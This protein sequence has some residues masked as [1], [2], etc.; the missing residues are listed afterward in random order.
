MHLNAANLVK[1]KA[2]TGWSWIKYGE[3][4][5]IC[6]NWLR[7]TFGYVRGSLYKMKKNK[8]WLDPN[9]F[10]SVRSSGLPYI[11]RIKAYLSYCCGSTGRFTFNYHIRRIVI[12]FYLLLGGWLWRY[13]WM[14]VMNEIM[15]LPR[16]YERKYS[17]IYDCLIIDL[18]TKL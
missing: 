9:L 8:L 15:K 17:R 2:P 5:Y 1:I 16:V 4:N 14:F 13:W 10:S 11:C 6:W 12:I 18:G 7:N 3:S